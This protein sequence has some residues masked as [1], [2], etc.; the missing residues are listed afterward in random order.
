MT[1]YNA[2]LAAMTVREIGKT[3]SAHGTVSAAIASYYKDNRF[4]SLAPGTQKLRRPILERFRAE[5]GDKR[6]AGL[7]K[8]HVAAILGAKKPWAARN[9]LKT[10]RGLMQFAIVTGL[11]GSDPTADLEPA[12]AKAGRFHTWTEDEIAQFE[13]RHPIGTRARLA[14]A[15]LLYTGQRRGDVVRMGPQH[16]GRGVLSVTQQKTGTELAIPVHPRLSEIITATECGHLAFLVTTAGGVF[17]G[18]RFSDQ[19][20]AWCDEAGLSKRC[21]AHG[22]RKAACRR[23]AET[24]CSAPQ[25][26]AISG[27]K[28]L[29]E[30]QRYIEEA[31]QARL[32]QAAMRRMTGHSENTEVSNLHEE[33]VYPSSKSST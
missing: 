2:A 12:K 24:G 14:M 26:A 23:L 21:S 19:F 6:L 33:S 13:A 7:Q 22:L 16:I 11:I 30:V 20:R 15:L 25:I 5:H 3:R 9:W 27:H 31:D 10:L 1:A 4:T 17:S 8:Q 18:G 28:T 32:A 29:K